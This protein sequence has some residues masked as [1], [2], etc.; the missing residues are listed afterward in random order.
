MTKSA[1]LVQ[2]SGTQTQRKGTSGPLVLLSLGCSGWGF[3]LSC[4]RESVALVAQ[5]FQRW[6]PLPNHFLLEL[7]S[8]IFPGP[9]AHLPVPNVIQSAR[10]GIRFAGADRVKLCGLYNEKN[11]DIVDRLL[12]ICLIYLP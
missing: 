3:C 8:C 11:E 10:Y 6:P 9:L 12:S 7:K 1:T 5:T 4:Y 2:P